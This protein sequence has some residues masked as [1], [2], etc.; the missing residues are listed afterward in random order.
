MSLQPLAQRRLEST[1]C[2]WSR[3]LLDQMTYWSPRSPG[4]QAA[5]AAGSTHGAP[6]TCLDWKSQ[7]PQHLT[8]EQTAQAT[9]GCQLSARLQSQCS[10]HWHALPPT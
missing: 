4:Q 10:N 1:G 8:E 5:V 2:V 7:K 6:P 3:R 9:V